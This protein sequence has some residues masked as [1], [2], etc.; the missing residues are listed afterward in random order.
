MYYKNSWMK[1]ICKYTRPRTK[2]EK[3]KKKQ[4]S[5]DY[6]ACYSAFS[7]STYISIIFSYAFIKLKMPLACCIKFRLE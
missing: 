5:N 6:T 4:T 1:M 7:T 3:K 2:K